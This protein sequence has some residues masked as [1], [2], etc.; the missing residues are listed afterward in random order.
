[1]NCSLETSG[2]GKEVDPAYRSGTGR[3]EGGKG[4][5]RKRETLTDFEPQLI[6]Y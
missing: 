2:R 5:G 4:R 1:M 6:S 3:L